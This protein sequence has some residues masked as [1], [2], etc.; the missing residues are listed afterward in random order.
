MGLDNIDEEMRA[1]VRLWDKK[2]LKKVE[3]AK[4]DESKA[5]KTLAQ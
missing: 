1:I 5:S 3:A 2:A 4:L